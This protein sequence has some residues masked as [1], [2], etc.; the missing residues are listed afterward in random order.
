MPASPNIDLCTPKEVIHMDLHY[1]AGQL[2][3]ERQPETDRDQVEPNAQADLP[4][5]PGQ[6]CSQEQRGHALRRAANL[7]RRQPKTG[8]SYYDPLF[9]APDTVENDYY[10]FRHQP[11]G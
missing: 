9:Q 3:R 5:L 10:R 6:G 2:V 8:P 11:R 7:L 1:E 4:A